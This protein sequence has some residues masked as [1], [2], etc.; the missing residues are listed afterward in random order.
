MHEGLIAVCGNRQDPQLKR[1]LIDDALFDGVGELFQDQEADFRHECEEV[2]FSGTWKAD[3]DEIMTL[4]LPPSAH[5]LAAVLLGSAVSETS[6]DTVSP[7]NLANEEI[8]GLAIALGARKVLVQKYYDSQTLRPGRFLIPGVD[9]VSFG[10]TDASAL[11]FDRTLACIVE[12]DLLKFKSL[13]AL[14]RVIDTTDIFRDATAEEVL[15]FAQQPLIDTPD[16]EGFVSATGQVSRRLIHA[17]QSSGML[18]SQTI[19]SLQ[20][21]ASQIGFTL[22]V[23][24]GR[25]RMPSASKE[26]KSLLQFLNDDLF[27]G[28]ISGE[29][30]VTNSKRKQ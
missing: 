5:A 19:Q 6:M 4:P 2:P 25:I 11:T 3:K 1:I 15:H 14:G 17:I 13:T 7:S 22:N 20:Q 10:R 9:G 24:S 26:I 21:A 23:V 29:N 27:R 30:Y 12:D 8:R 18:A 16:P 28:A